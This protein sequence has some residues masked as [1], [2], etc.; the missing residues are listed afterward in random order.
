MVNFRG[1]F[2][3]GETSLFNA[4][5]IMMSSF[6][7]PPSH[8]WLL[9]EWFSFTL[10]PKCNLNFNLRKSLPLENNELKRKSPFLS[11]MSVPSGLH[12]FVSS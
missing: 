11:E 6:T 2:V 9:R 8:L 4:A 1:P 5:L 12:L 7:S 10:L 3:P